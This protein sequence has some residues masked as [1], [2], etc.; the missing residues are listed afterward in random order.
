MS[1]ELLLEIF[2]IVVGL[3]MYLVAFNIF[4]CQENQARIGTTLFWAIL[5]TIFVFGSYLPGTV[6]GI[7]LLVIGVLTATKQASAL[8]QKGKSEW[9]KEALLL[10]KT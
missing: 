6:V 7:L 2:Y 3:L 1:N 4:K 5:G 10:L 9:R 8:F